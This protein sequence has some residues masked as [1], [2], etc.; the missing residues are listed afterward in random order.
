MEAGIE[1]E[2]VVVVRSSSTMLSS[3]LRLVVDQ[4][5]GP[6]V[7]VRVPNV[8]VPHGEALA[9]LVGV[10]HPSSLV[11]L[12]HDCIV[13]RGGA[14]GGGDES[15][16]AVR[17]HVVRSGDVTSCDGGVGGHGRG[18]HVV[19]GVGEGAGAV[20]AVHAAV[21]QLPVHNATVAVLEL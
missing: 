3:D 10:H 6:A 8:Q 17:G 18:L 13:V 21:T 1:V 2:R 15:A 5:V 16:V 14:V 12:P 19:L 20:G 7:G 4:G 9:V 11:L